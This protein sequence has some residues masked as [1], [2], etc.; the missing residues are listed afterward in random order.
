MKARQSPSGPTL[1]NPSFGYVDNGNTGAAL[2]VDFGTGAL[3]L[4]NVNQNTSLTFA[5]GPAGEKFQGI[6]KV[7]HGPAFT[8]AFPG[9]RTPGGT[10]LTLSTGAT[11]VDLIQCLWDGAH[12]NLTVLGLNF[13]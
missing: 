2:Q 4:V 9:A 13:S 6:L 1:Q 12:W 3:Q 5:N 11:Q 7:V 10:P 8:V